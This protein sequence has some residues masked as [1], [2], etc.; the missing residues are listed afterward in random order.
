MLPATDVNKFGFPVA[1]TPM[2]F[3]A[4]SFQLTGQ[5]R[6]ALITQA[7]PFV[8]NWHRRNVWRDCLADTLEAFVFRLSLPL[9]KEKHLPVKRKSLSFASQYKLL[10]VVLRLESKSSADLYPPGR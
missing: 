7:H 10:R 5:A 8:G 3:I 6:F 4:L 1:A 2:E 9:S